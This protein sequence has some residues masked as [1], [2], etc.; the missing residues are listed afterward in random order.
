MIDNY[1]KCHG[2]GNDITDLNDSAL[3]ENGYRYHNTNTFDNC[4]RKYIEE[5]IRKPQE[6]DSN[7]NITLYCVICRKQITDTSSATEISSYGLMHRHCSIYL[8]KRMHAKKCGWCGNDID[9]VDGDRDENYSLDGETY[10]HL[11]ENPEFSCY[12][13]YQKSMEDYNKVSC[14]INNCSVK[15]EDEFGSW[16]HHLLTCHTVDEIVTDLIGFIQDR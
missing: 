10:Y 9:I 13:K 8:T 7:N 3:G 11:K 14:Y 16:N 15:V 12:H 6:K 2:C 4:Y 5:L 1:I